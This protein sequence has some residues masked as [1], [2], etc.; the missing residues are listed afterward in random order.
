MDYLAAMNSEHA[1][2]MGV[3]QL[4]GL[5]GQLPKRIE[6]IRVLVAELNR[7]ASHCLAIGTYGMDL[8]ATTAFMWLMRDREH[9][10][11][12]LEWLTGA[13]ML[14]KLHLDW[15]V[16]T[17]ICLLDL[18]TVVLNSSNTLKKNG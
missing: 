10:V 18:K 7:I 17:M 3:E 15:R 6:Y 1:F 16:Y 14:Y 12:L 13:R 8:G 5:A 4:L 9:I 2:A 11:R